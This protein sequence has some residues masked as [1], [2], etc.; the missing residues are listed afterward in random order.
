[1][2]YYS[3]IRHTSPSIA[4]FFTHLGTLID[5]S[6]DQLGALSDCSS[7]QRLQIRDFVLGDISLGLVLGNLYPLLH[8]SLAWF[9]SV[10]R[11]L[12]RESIG[13]EVRSSDLETGSSS[14]AGT[15]GAETNT[16]TSVP[17]SSHPSIPATPQTFHALKEKCSLKVDT[18]SRF[19][20][21]F[22]FPEETRVH[23]PR[24]GKKAYTFAHGEVCFYKAA[25][26]CG[27]RFP[28][29]LFIMELLHHLNI[30][31]GQLMPNSWRIVIS[32]MVI[33]TTI[34]NW[35]MITL[36]EL[37]HLYYL[38]ESKEFGYY[39]LVP[40]IESLVSLSTSHCPSIIGSLGISSCPVMVGNPF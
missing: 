10:C 28:I 24:K 34:A 4:F 26:L 1:M 3:E 16:S 22:Q 21:R 30:A 8:Q 32:C 37:I 29:H 35:E 38:K 12:R 39:E 31:P 6:S 14:S 17:S 25:F 27:L 33:W 7:D 36:N 11:V 19:R 13:S 23:L 5:S 40:G 9:K 15:V 20:D 18:F 2:V